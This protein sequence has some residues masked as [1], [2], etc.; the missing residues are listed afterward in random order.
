MNN[1]NREKINFF[2]VKIKGMINK[3]LINNSTMLK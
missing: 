2:L 1:I 3:T